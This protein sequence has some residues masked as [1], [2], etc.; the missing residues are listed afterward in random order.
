MLLLQFKKL[1]VREKRDLLHYIQ[2]LIPLRP[3]GSDHSH[4]L[5]GFLNSLC[6]LSLFLSLPPSPH[7][8]HHYHPKI[9]TWVVLL[10]I[11]S[12]ITHFLWPKS[13]NVSALFLKVKVTTFTMAC[14]VLHGFGPYHLSDLIYACC[15][16]GYSASAILA[17]LLFLNMTNMV[18][19]QDLCTSA[20]NPLPIYNLMATSLISLM[21]LLKWQLLQRPTLTALLNSTIWLFLPS[22]KQMA[23]TPI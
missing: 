16:S 21:P 22:G 2:D 18:L 12:Q 3:H 15:A 17:S 13:F 5:L 14:K 9:A 7:S 20:K 19:P 11:L 4:L 8:L 10:E 6:L 23:L 1:R